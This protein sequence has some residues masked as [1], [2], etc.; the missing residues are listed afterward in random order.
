MKKNILLL[1]IILLAASC[2]NQSQTMDTQ[3]KQEKSPLDKM[4]ELKPG[5]KLSAI[6]ETSMGDFRVELYTDKAPK[7]VRNFVGLSLEGFYNGISFHRVIKDFMIQGGDP[8]GTGSGGKSIYGSPFED[9][10]HPSLMHD[11]PGILSMANAGPRT[12]TS[13]FFITLAPTPWLNAK[14]SIFGKVVEGLEIVQAIGNTKTDQGDRPLET[15]TILKLSIEK[16]I[17]D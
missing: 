3:S 1:F 11:S 14:H 15:V 10:F 7:T 4:M 16:N 2:N 5:E 8:T 17:S 9:E 6:F 13:Q 12:N